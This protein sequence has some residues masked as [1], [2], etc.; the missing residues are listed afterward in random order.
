MITSAL[1]KKI[2]SEAT[3]FT[4][5]IQIFIGFMNRCKIWEAKLGD[6]LSR[7]LSTTEY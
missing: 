6:H 1:E 3:G 4:E 5:D 2:T 7:V